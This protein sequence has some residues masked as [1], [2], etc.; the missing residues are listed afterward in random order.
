MSGFQTNDRGNVA[1]LPAAHAVVTMKGLPSLGKVVSSPAQ[2]GAQPTEPVTRRVLMPGDDSIT[3]WGDGNDFPQRII[4]LAHKNAII[5]Q[6][7][8]DKVALWIGGGVRATADPKSE[9]MVDD[10]EIYDFLNDVTFERYLLEVMTDMAWWRNAWPEFILSRDRKTI[11]QLHNNEAAYCRW[12]RMNEKTGSLDSVY[13]NANWPQATAQD[14][15]TKRIPVINP[16][17]A[18]RVEW[19]RSQNGFKFIYP[20]SLPSPGKSYYQV[21]A[22]D[23]AR[24]SGWL[25]VLAAIPQFKKFAM[26]NQMTIRYHIE[27]P[28]EY[29]ENVYGEQW[30]KAD[31]AGKMSIRDA[32]LT[33][34]TERL[35]GVDNANKSVLTDKW[36]DHNGN[37]QRVVINVLD[38]KTKDGKFNDDYSEGLAALAYAMG[39]DPALFGFQGKDFS[40]SG[41][42][43]KREAFWIFLSKSAP[44]RSRALEP[45]KFIA[46]YNGWKQ[47]YPRLTFKLEDTILTTL[48]TGHSTAKTQTPA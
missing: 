29:W 38:D 46:E 40:R 43:D 24:A 25:D 32:F 9:D 6:A 22:W 8:D 5:E 14:A 36:Y 21:S 18:D 2:L 28:Q 3:F 11:V 1:F 35:T 4:E 12:G 37:E 34:L 30:D 33:N 42:S 7:L 39:I 16:Y 13:I 44:S 45:L 15:E 31:D 17:R 26:Q 48:D 20:L 41:G 19:V 27:V 23:A 47:R 10:Q